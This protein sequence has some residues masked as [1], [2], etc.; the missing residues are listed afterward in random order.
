MKFPEPA[1]C[2][3]DIATRTFSSYNVAYFMFHLCL[4]CGIFFWQTK[5]FVNGKKISVYSPYKVLS[6]GLRKERV[7][8]VNE[9]IRIY[10]ANLCNGEE[11]SMIKT[12]AAKSF[13]SESELWST[14]QQFL[15]LDISLTPCFLSMPINHMPESNT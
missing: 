10:I 11:P 6:R 8:Y 1:F 12:L 2:I 15:N 3:F 14:S 13:S 4:N 5:P 9:N 7:H